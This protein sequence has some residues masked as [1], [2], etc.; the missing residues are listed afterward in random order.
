MKYHLRFF[1]DDA[2]CCENIHVFEYSNTSNMLIPRIGEHVWLPP[3]NDDNDDDFFDVRYRVFD[4]EYGTYNNDNFKI[5]DVFV[6][7]DR[8]EEE[9]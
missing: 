8:K 5:V 6:T 3:V 9:C 1:I 2:D 4:V 7:K